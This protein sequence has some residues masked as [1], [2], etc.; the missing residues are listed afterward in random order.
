MPFIISDENKEEK[1]IQK[2]ITVNVNNT[3]SNKIKL[4]MDLFSCVESGHKMIVFFYL[5]EKVVSKSSL[6]WQIKNINEIKIE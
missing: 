5:K 1:L 6:K 3:V 4:F 2:K